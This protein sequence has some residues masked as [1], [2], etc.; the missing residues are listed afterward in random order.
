MLLASCPR[1]MLRHRPSSY[2]KSRCEVPAGG[3][4]GGVILA[5]ASGGLIQPVGVC[6][7]H[8]GGTN[9]SHSRYKY[10]DDLLALERHSQREKDSLTHQPA[11]NIPINEWEPFLAR[12]PDQVFAAYLRRGFTEGF[13]IGFDCT[14]R[15]RKAPQ[16]FR[17]VQANPATVEQYIEAELAAGR[18]VESAAP[19][20]RRNPIGIITKPHQPGRFRLIVDLSAP[21]GAS[22]VSMMESPLNYL[23]WYTSQ[24][25]RQPDWWLT[26]VKAL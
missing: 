21:R 6:S 22:L 18:L 9:I 25:I 7:L 10:T 20:T 23:P 17:S 14:T 2:E 12:H 4:C 11:G 16:N 13:R 5:A 8:A 26:A 1:I 15:L 3:L 19:M 24:W